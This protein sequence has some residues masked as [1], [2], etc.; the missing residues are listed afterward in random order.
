M[1]WSGRRDHLVGDMNPLTVMPSSLV[2]EAR[3]SLEWSSVPR[4]SVSAMLRKIEDKKQN[5]MS[6]QRNWREAQKVW[7]PLKILK[8]VEDALYNRFFIIDVIVSDDGSTMQAVLKHPSKGARG[9]V[10]KSS[11]GK[12]DKEIP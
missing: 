6:A 3:G 7:G 12:L 5:N 9:Q 8:M 1:M 10:L 2:G 11:K 4:P